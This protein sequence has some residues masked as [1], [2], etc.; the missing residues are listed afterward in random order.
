MIPVIPQKPAASVERRRHVRQKTCSIVCVKLDNDNGGILLNL[1]TGGLSFQAVAQIDRDRDLILNFKLPDG[2][3]AIQIEGKVAWLGPTRKEAGICFR[4]LPDST[5]QRISGWIEM[6][7]APTEAKDWR[8]SPRAKP[9]PLTTERPFLPPRTETK[10]I[11]ARLPVATQKLNL[12]AVLPSGPPSGGSLPHSDPITPIAPVV[13]ANSSQTPIPT[14][15]IHPEEHSTVSI[16]DSYTRPPEKGQ[17]MNQ[18]K[19]P[20]PFEHSQEISQ[21][22]EAS[23]AFTE[24]PSSTVAAVRNWWFRP[25][26]I[27]TPAVGRRNRT[28]LIGVGFAT[29][30]VVLGLIVISPD[31]SV[32]LERIHSSV[33][34]MLKSTPARAV[35]PDPRAE[36]MSLESKQQTTASPIA[37]SDSSNGLAPVPASPKVAR[38]S[39]K[40]GLLLML[41]RMFPGIKNPGVSDQAVTGVKVWTHQRSGYYYCADSPYFEKLQPG[42]IMLQSDALQ[43]GYQPKLGGYCE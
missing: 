9:S 30:L 25:V 35:A 17:T 31:Y 15:P 28:R 43:K 42:S 11:P 16:L 38:V 39:A 36:G 22:V 20:S 1:G 8:V 33:S 19:L 34:A 24:F 29:C 6:Q 14:L 7:G 18:P 40:A 3:E 32:Y 41:K 23:P 21:P 12:S 37:P 2:P 26:L 5:Q 13:L 10:P 4:D 27:V